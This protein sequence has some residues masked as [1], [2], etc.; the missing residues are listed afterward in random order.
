L[1]IDD[2]NEY[3]AKLNTHEGTAK[4]FDSTYY[5]TAKRACLLMM[6]MNTGQS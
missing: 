5:S 2:A 4:L 1:L 3:R 6:Q